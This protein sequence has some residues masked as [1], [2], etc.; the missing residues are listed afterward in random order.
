MKMGT[1]FRD[2]WNNPDFISPELR[3]SID[4]EVETVEKA[5]EAEKQEDSAESREA[6]SVGSKQ[7]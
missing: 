6:R 1:N 5:I 4:S 2:L 7:V 3:V